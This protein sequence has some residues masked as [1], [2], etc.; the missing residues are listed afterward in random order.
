[1]S[2]ACNISADAKLYGFRRCATPMIYHLHEE[3]L[4][5]HPREQVFEFFCSAENLNLMTP[6][7]V[8]FSIVTPTPIEMR[9][10]TIIDYRISLY[11]VPFKWRSEISVW[12]PPHEFCDSQVSGPYRYWLH[13]HTFVET[14]EGTLV[15]DHVDYRVPYGWPVQKLFV[16]R[17][18]R[19]IFGYRR[20]RLLEIFS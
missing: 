15:T 10:G 3:L 20:K 19:R 5:N 18:L 2:G 8:R 4:L 12:D 14:G 6:P 7:W 16:A 13:R 11:R 17:E 1:M 9:L